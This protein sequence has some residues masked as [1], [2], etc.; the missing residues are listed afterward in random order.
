MGQLFG[1]YCGLAVSLVIGPLNGLSGFSVS[2]D[3]GPQ[4]W[5][6]SWDVNLRTKWTEILGTPSGGLDIGP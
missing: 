5:T 2:V 6:A 3:T 4:H 1:L